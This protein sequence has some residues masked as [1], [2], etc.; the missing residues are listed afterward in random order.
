MNHIKNIKDILWIVRPHPS[1]SI[2]GEQGIVENVV[3][4]MNCQNI[5]ICP[6]KVNTDNLVEITDGVVTGRG[7]IALEFASSGKPALIAGKCSFSDL[8]FLLEPKNKKEYMYFLSN[9]DKLK[10]L[11]KNQIEKARKTSMY[12]ENHNENHVFEN[13][14]IPYFKR[15]NLKTVLKELNQNL[16]KEYNFLRSKYFLNISNR[17][18]NL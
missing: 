8:G 4:K 16:N 5:K 6:K 7:K 10:L 18:K 11:N 17:I 9:F 2:Y 1:S 15:R 14:L 3:K 12:L 13:K